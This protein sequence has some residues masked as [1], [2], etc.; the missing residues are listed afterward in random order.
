MTHKC[1]KL[2]V[3]N[4][5]FGFLKR[6]KRAADPDVPGPSDS[7][8]RRIPGRPPPISNPRVCERDTEQNPG[9]EEEKSSPVLFN[10]HPGQNE[11]VKMVWFPLRR[12]G[13]GSVVSEEAK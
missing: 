11:N 9:G 10:L 2:T 6:R 3:S 8:S 13:T 1:T 5:C 12:E 7:R 4:V